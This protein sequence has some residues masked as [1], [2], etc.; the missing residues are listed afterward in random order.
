MP[1]AIPAI[2][3]AVSAI[4]TAASAYSSYQQ[5]QAQQSAAKQQAD[6]A[7]IQG[8]MDNETA[9]FQAKSAEM[10][11]QMIE[12]EGKEAKRVGYENAQK[13]RLEAA[14]MVGQQRLA[15]ASSGAQVDQGS[16]LDKQLDTV[17]KGELDALASNEQGLWED[18]NK[19]LQAAGERSKAIGYAGAGTMAL[20]KARGQS[21]LFSAKANSYTPWLPAGTSLL[22]GGNSLL[23][24]IF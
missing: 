13:K 12:D 14:G 19:R 5:G 11:A 6:A 10:N 21:S 18:Y 15:A 22:K 1:Q 24:Q 17:E 3:L 8:M 9:Q 7:M 20:T 16:F 2:G 4:G 23:K